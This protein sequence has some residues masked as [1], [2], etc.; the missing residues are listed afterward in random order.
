MFGKHKEVLKTSVGV[1]N[2]VLLR[3]IEKELGGTIP[4]KYAFTEDR[5]VKTIGKE[6]QFISCR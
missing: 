5:I 2:E 4:E 1:D 6:K 3:Y